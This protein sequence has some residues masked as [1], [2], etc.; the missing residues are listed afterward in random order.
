MQSLYIENSFTSESCSN[1]WIFANGSRRARL[2]YIIVDRKVHSRAVE[3]KV[4][5]DVDIGSD[6]RPLVLSFELG[7]SSARLKRRQTVIR[8]LADHNVSSYRL[9]LEERLMKYPCDARDTTSMASYIEEHVEN[10]MAEVAEK[11][12]ICTQ[13]RLPRWMRTSNR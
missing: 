13:K 5:H 11:S 12:E 6:H 10:A 8:P 7:V 4:M 9:T 2:D 1:L 3:C